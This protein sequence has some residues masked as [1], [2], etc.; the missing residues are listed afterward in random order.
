MARKIPPAQVALILNGGSEPVVTKEHYQIEMM[1][2]L[3]WYNIHKTEKECRAYAE[4]Y[5]KHTPEFKPYAKYLNTAWYQLIKPVAVLGRLIQRGQYVSDSDKQRIVTFLDDIKSRY[6]EEKPTEKS[7]VVKPNIQDKILGA[8]KTHAAD[9]EG[10][11]DRAITEKV[12]DFSVK[13]YL[14]ANQVSAVAA[15]KIGPMFEKRIAEVAEALQGK[16]PQLAEGYSYFKKTELKK[17]YAW[18]Q[19]I[20]K[21]CDQQVVSAKVARK[22]RVVK[23]KPPSVVAAK[24][25]PMREYPELE[26][27]SVDPAKIIGATELWVYIPKTRKLAVFYGN[28]LLDVKGTAILNYNVEKSV[29]KTIRKPEEFFKKLSST[30]KRAMANAWKEIKT[31]ES[32]PRNRINGDMVLLAVN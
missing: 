9:I 3:N 1:R 27:S 18:L 26:L 19:Q 12:F 15:K 29:S 13:D 20:V 25:K 7:A 30:G 32:K 21:D 10:E 4:Y 16:C 22:P 2:A 5:V 6:V 8:A 11:I 17:Y 24:I 23:V 14:V 31:T 28:E